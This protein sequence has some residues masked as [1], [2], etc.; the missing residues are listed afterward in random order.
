MTVNPSNQPAPDNL[1]SPVSRPVSST[2]SSTPVAVNELSA[3]RQLVELKR[4][5]G[6]T[7][8]A[9]IVAIEP[10]ITDRISSREQ[11]H[12]DKATQLQA[13]ERN[14]ADTTTGQVALKT[15]KQVWHITLRLAN[16]KQTVTT[17][18]TALQLPRG[19]K[20][21]QTLTLSVDPESGLI[22][23]PGSSVNEGSAVSSLLQTLA[24][25]IPLQDNLKNH[26]AALISLG[27]AFP[28][29]A[30]SPLVKAITNASP[31][32][33]AANGVQAEGTNG[34]AELLWKF[35]KEKIAD[36]SLP[37]SKLR[38]SVTPAEKS[39]NS[40]AVL[41]EADAR[42]PPVIVLNELI[43]EITKSILSP[44]QSR[45]PE[46]L[47][48]GLK[49]S[50]ITMEAKLLARPVALQSMPEEFA[51]WLR[52]AIHPQPLQQ[53]PD[54]AESPLLRSAPGDLKALLMTA[55]AISADQSAQSGFSGG[56]GS[57]RILSAHWEGL[58]NWLSPRLVNTGPAHHPLLF[59]NT[60]HSSS[61]MGLQPE[62]MDAADLLRALTQA[63]ARI[64][65]NQLNALQMSAGMPGEPSTAQY[66]FMELPILGQHLNM[67]QIRLEKETLQPKKNRHQ[68]Q[69]R[70]VLA[71]DFEQLGPL[72]SHVLYTNGT[73]SATF[74]ANQTQTLR[75]VNKELPALRQGLK[76]W[77]IQVGDLAVRKGSPPTLKT[78]VSYRLLDEEV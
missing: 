14:Q 17:E 2:G 46:L 40:G 15:I 20:P 8:K 76:D 37:A 69:W 53:P 55:L 42:Q 70:L 41:S 12:Y 35:I 74:W 30:G 32:T 33:K 65:V 21:G 10:Q 9:T 47:K 6:S 23:K 73:V 28:E 71:F 77:G 67:V 19:W 36:G 5:L 56:T 62:I 64:Q 52:R 50:G 38:T 24:R 72:Q 63:L 60:S 13:P 22:F 11:L 78:P 16:L 58:M 66:W 49:N 31:P 29:D 75:L 4:S 57:D 44:E 18:L 43:K 25:F 27:R 3:T 7:V 59:P 54:I 39:A 61:S 45:D 48:N 1:Q 26:L 68:H 34:K 51:A